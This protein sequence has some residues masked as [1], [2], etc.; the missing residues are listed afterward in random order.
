[1]TLDDPHPQNL[2]EISR[3]SSALPISNSWDWSESEQMTPAAHTTHV[4]K[5]TQILPRLF[6]QL[7]GLSLDALDLCAVVSFPIWV[8]EVLHHLSEGS[9]LSYLGG[10]PHLRVGFEE[11]G[12]LL[13]LAPVGFDSLVDRDG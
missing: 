12:E 11:L 8:L 1:M 5:L 3:S 4:L 13:S 6:I 7:L 2:L 9:I 10:I